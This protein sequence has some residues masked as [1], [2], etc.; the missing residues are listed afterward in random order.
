MAG[1]RIERRD[2]PGTFYKDLDQHGIQWTNWLPHASFGDRKL[3]V[4]ILA[5]LKGQ[6]FEVR[7][8]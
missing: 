1:Y 8:V 2:Q 3:M 4:G 7:L 6:G 5:W